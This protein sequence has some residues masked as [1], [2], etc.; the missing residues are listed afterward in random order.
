[1]ET[2]GAKGSA[3]AINTDHSLTQ[4]LVPSINNNNKRIFDVI[5]KNVL[6]KKAL[7]WQPGS[8]K[9]GLKGNRENTSP[10]FRSF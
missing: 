1:M 2:W 3:G 7:L 10:F 4:L 8:L 6:Q 9:T 5:Y